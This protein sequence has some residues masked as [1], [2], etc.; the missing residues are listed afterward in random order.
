MALTSSTPCPAEAELSRFVIRA[1][2]ATTAAGVETHLAD[3]TDCR[4]LVFALA[5]STGEATGDAAPAVDRIGRFEMLDLIGRGAMGAV[6][7]ARDP[8]LE[9]VVAIKLRHLQSRL[10]AEQEDRLRREAQAL[11]RLADP[12][13]VGVFETGV[14]DGKPFV[15][16][17]Y[18]A[19]QTLERWMASPHGVPAVL[20]MLAQAGRGLAAAHAVG[21][22]HRDFKPSNVLVSKAGVAKVGDFGLVRLDGE[23]TPRAQA[24][25]AVD[26]A[27]VLTMT[28]AL[29]G[30]P[31]YMAPEQLEGHAATEASDQFSFCVTLYEALYG[32]RPF[33]GATID[34]LRAAMN[35]PL[36][37]PAAP[38]LPPPIRAALLRGLAVD[39]AKR[40]PAMSVLVAVLERQ[41]ARV[42]PW[43]LAVTA[44]L[45]GAAVIVGL[46]M[47][48]ATDP[49]S[50]T[51]AELA[52]AW[53]APTKE[54]IKTRL[55]AAKVPYAADAWRGVEKALDAYAS[56]WT[57]ARRAACEATRVNGEQTEQVL[58]LRDQCL[59]GRA[60]EL[61]ALT[62]ALTTAD[63]KM[64]SRSVTAATRLS[65]VAPCADIRALSER[66]PASFTIVRQRLDQLQG[67][68]AQSRTAS[69][70][71]KVKD[72]IATLD[73][74][75]DAA[76]REGYP[77][78]LAEALI[79]QG[80]LKFLVDG[81]AKAA[82]KTLLTAL[83]AAD[84]GRDDYLR[85]RAWTLLLFLVGNAQARVDEA[86]A[87]FQHGLAT[88]QRLV[89]AEGLEAQ[90]L[91]NRGQM[92]TMEGKLAEAEP[93]LRKTLAVMERTQGPDHPEIAI[94]LAALSELV[95]RKGDIAEGMALAVRA[96]EMDNRIYG[97]NHPSTAKSL[98]NVAHA[99]ADEGKYDEAAE[100][101]QKTIAILEAA[102]GPEHIDLANAVDELGVIRRHQDRL[103][104][105]L[106][107]HERS[108]ALREKTLG[109]DHPETGVSL[110]N[111]GIVLGQLGRHAEALADHRRA[112]AI[113]EATLGP[114]TGD[115]AASHGYL[116]NTLMAMNKPKEAFTEFQIALK[117]VE[118]QLGP[119]HSD[120]SFYLSGMGHA[121]LDQ[122]QPKEA[123]PYLERSLKLR[124]ADGDPVATAEVQF[125]IARAL[126]GSGGDRQRA[127]SL[128]EQARP[129]VKP[130][131]Q[132]T[133]AAWLT[134]PN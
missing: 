12:N 35:Q 36:A 72:A 81:D 11:A 101:I 52:G 60:S 39:P 29:L 96:Y 26:P 104:E 77:A 34:Q 125:A 90:L 80:R 44:L 5:S 54:A 134:A 37:L 120:L 64:V 33:A 115:A 71:G 6:Y 92:L 22:V 24:A 53:D 15:A 128:A 107:L 69:S 31:A 121:L 122:K 10:D 61:R 63:Q 112:L 126:W 94:A 7:R 88:V 65:P 100:R 38:R 113:T 40:H 68:I 17:E 116:A 78:V 13:V 47:R 73:G 131:D 132:P 49:C 110:D 95:M 19:G 127:R 2:P 83:W 123:L 57:Q 91:G 27:M 117:L 55:L 124:N 42:L 50:G 14:A 85:A 70:L 106:K 41:P 28:G 89:G 58:A 82:E 51:E 98:F 87:L 67:A 3:C 84:R 114:D 105:A 45:G 9:R 86:D 66:A 25:L 97:P 32:N 20:A 1:L 111:R 119:E 48:G 99:M 109:P 129:N 79:E 18:V 23:A 43:V 103:E 133:V 118:K 130:A 21:L 108:L 93:L 56:T 75:I 46:Q 62:T 59:D 8:E 16:M 76:K 102:L 74:V 4:N 30:T